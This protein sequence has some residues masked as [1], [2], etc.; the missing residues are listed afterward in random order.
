[1]DLRV[2]RY[3]VRIVESGGFGRAAEQLHITQP[4]LSKA[5]R[6][7]EE[8]LEAVLLE[9]GKRGSQ[10][11]LTPSGEIVLRHART[12]LDERKR[13]AR[14]IDELRGLSGGELRIGLSPLGSAELFAPLIARF[15]SRYPQVRVWLM[16]RGGA[17]LEESL[18]KGDIELATSLVPVHDGIDWLQ[19]RNDPMRVALPVAHPLAQQESIKLK[20]LAEVP[21]VIFEPGFLLNKVVLEACY[22]AGFTPKVVTQI[23]QPDFGL[24][25]VAAGT[26]A[27]LLPGLIAERHGTP[28]VRMIALED[29]SFTW[30]LSL[31]WRKGG[32]LTFAARAMLDLIE[33]S[34][35]EQGSL[36]GLPMGTV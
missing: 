12:M 23:S 3:F 6:S 18:R 14:A 25:L 15:R 31:L 30:K 35:D 5:I 27:M 16:E 33:S 7:L 20:D 24:A 29:N 28:G 21:L 9:R 17:E 32:T 11:R 34:L 8:E 13:M 10:I 2:L 19:I 22:T 4:A 1:M 36:P 26:G